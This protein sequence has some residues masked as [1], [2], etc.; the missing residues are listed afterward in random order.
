L[1]RA[2][3]GLETLTAGGV[4]WDGEDLTRTVVHRRRFGLMFQQHALF[5]HRDVE[6]NV[7]FGLRM[8][9][10]P[11]AEVGTRVHATLDLVGMLGFEKRR[12]QQLS[13]GE[14]QRVALAR[15][16]APEPRFLML[17]E[18]F[19]SLDRARREQLVEEVGALVR[20]LGL[21]TLLVTHDHDEAFAVAD[22]VAVMN[23]GTVVQVGTPTQLWEEP[24]SP[25]VARF[26]GWNL[27]HDGHEFVAVRPDRVRLDD[28]GPIDG[29]VT[30]V[31][32]KQGRFS[33]GV[34][35]DLGNLSVTVDSAPPGPGSAVKLR[36]TG[37]RRWDVGDA[38]AHEPAS[39]PDVPY[40]DRS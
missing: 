26:L 14:Q 39:G 11:R 33:V 23:S 6:S 30:R 17:D 9:G 25:F 31:A 32:L 22:R 20:A 19:G 5:P 13:G 16:L 37:E 21:S 15:A 8:Q 28:T 40:P 2:I 4:H 34:R 7:A 1:L 38:S 12:V 10:L 29:V 18:P 27:V 35:T 36:L 3:A 24:S